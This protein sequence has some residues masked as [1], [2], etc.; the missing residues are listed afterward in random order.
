MELALQEV[1]PLQTI[2]TQTFK[3][4]Y[5]PTFAQTGGATIKDLEDIMKKLYKIAKEYRDEYVKYVRNTELQNKT[6]N[7][8]RE[9]RVF[10]RRTIYCK[11]RLVYDDLWKFS[12]SF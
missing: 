5:N 3:D 9:R 6:T 2:T 10:I 7:K 4:I 8:A 11:K 12:K 1:V